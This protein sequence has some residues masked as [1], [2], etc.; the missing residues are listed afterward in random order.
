MYVT[1]SIAYQ[2][3][4]VLFRS[5]QIRILD[6][7]MTIRQLKNLEQHGDK[8]DHPA[9]PGYHDDRSNALCLAATLAAERRQKRSFAVVSAVARSTS[10]QVHVS[11]TVTIQDGVVTVARPAERLSPARDHRLDSQSLPPWERDRDGDGPPEMSAR[12]AAAA[13]RGVSP[14]PAKQ[15]EIRAREDENRGA[16][17]HMLN[18]QPCRCNLPGTDH[19]RLWRDCFYGAGRKAVQEY[20]RHHPGLYR[21]GCSIEPAPEEEHA[22]GAWY[23]EQRRQGRL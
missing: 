8:V 21:P 1:R 6:D 11:P 20:R 16:P 15:A 13:W 7:A 19:Y 3:S 2:E 12:K 10:G 18:G 23:E 5:G 9:G 14:E 17:P 22:A 4:A